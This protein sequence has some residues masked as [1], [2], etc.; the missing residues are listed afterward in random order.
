MAAA[1]L[2]AFANIFSEDLDRLLII[3]D[4]IPEDGQE[5]WDD[6]PL[7]SQAENKP[8]PKRR[9]RNRFTSRRSSTENELTSR[10]FRV[11]KENDWNNP[12]VATSKK[13]TW[14]TKY[15]DRASSAVKLIHRPNPRKNVP[16]ERTGK[17]LNI[18][19]GEFHP[20]YFV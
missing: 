3:Y 13:D 1:F 2:F 6:K 16:D 12:R 9:A 11:E 4:D 18:A 10:G 14:M 7:L 8:K 20:K 15:Y 19:T 17:S 5:D